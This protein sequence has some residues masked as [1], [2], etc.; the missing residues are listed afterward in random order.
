MTAT[1]CDGERLVELDQIELGDV[2]PGALEQ[3]P[4]GGH[5][6]DAHHARVDAGDGARDESRRAARLRAPRARSSLAITSAAAP[7]FTPL[8]VACSDRTALAKHRLQRGELLG[9]RVGTRMLVALDA[10]HRDELVVETAGFG[11]RGPALLAS[12]TRR[13]PAP[14]A[15]R[16]SALRRSRPS[17]PSTRAGTAPPAA[18]SGSASRAACRTRQLLHRDRGARLAHE[19]RAAHRLDTAG[20]EEVAVARSDRVRRCNDGGEPRRA[21]AV[22]RHACHRLRQPREQHRHPRNVAVVF[23]RLVRCA[24]VDVFD[25]LRRNARPLDRGRDD[26]SPRDRPDG[27]RR[28][29]RLS[30]RSASG[31]RK[32]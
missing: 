20:D 23:A 10:V 18:D 19:R 25:L 21:E 5:G 9:A 17:R 4:H 31:H 22:D 24:E 28:A 7:S 26:E 14:P 29:R 11:R 27:S 30:A 3:L 32:G 6:A 16:P 12:A 1:L 2:E 15:T 13:H 8:A